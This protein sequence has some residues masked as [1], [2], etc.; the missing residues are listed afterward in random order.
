MYYFRF[1]SY[2]IIGLV[3]VSNVV[4]RISCLVLR[5]YEFKCIMEGFCFFVLKVNFLYLVFIGINYVVRSFVKRFLFIIL[6]EF[7]N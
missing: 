2:N 4:L 7:I 3:S 6:I 1:D 5:K